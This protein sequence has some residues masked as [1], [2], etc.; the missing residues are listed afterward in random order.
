MWSGGFIEE[1]GVGYWEEKGK[2]LGGL[3]NGLVGK[4]GW[5]VQCAGISG[6][7]SGKLIQTTTTHR[8]TSE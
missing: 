1:E 5:W 3:G 4:K 6:R 8:N 2:R 7:I